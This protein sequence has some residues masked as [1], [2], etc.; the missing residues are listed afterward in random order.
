MPA[1]VQPHNAISTSARRSRV[2]DPCLDARLLDR[3]GAAPY[4]PFPTTF[5]FV[6]F[7]PRANETRASPSSSSRIPNTRFVVTVALIVV[8]EFLLIGLNGL[9]IFVAVLIWSLLS[10]IHMER[11]LGPSTVST[12][13][14]Q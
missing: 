3:T 5:I 4:Q 6:H 7:I 14:Y 9:S 2:I 10:M 8:V 12:F 13:G 1:R 11:L